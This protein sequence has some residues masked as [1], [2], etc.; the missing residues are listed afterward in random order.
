MPEH[1]ADHEL[2][3]EGSRWP[4][5]LLNVEDMISYR[6]QPGNTY[7]GITEP[8][9]AIISYTWGRWRLEKGEQPRIEALPIKGVPWEVPRVDPKHFTVAQFRHVLRMVSLGVSNSGEQSAPA[10][11]FVWLDVAC[12]P[13]WPDS[14]VAASEI[15]RQARI[16]R[17]AQTA[18][19]WL[20]TPT[21]ED[22]ADLPQVHDLEFVKSHG[23][24][25]ALR[26]W[27]NLLKDP[28]FSSMW[29]LQESF[30]QQ[31]AY[32]VTN[33]G[34]Y[35]RMG[36]DRLITYQMEGLYA[37]AT[38]LSGLHK[39]FEGR[40]DFRGAEADLMQFKGRWRETGIG[41]ASPMAVLAA[42]IGRKCSF[43]LDRVYGIMQ[44]FG[45]DFVVGKAA[46]PAAA[47]KDRGFTLNELENDLGTLLLTRFPVISQL[48][49]H[50]EPPLVGRAWRICGRASVPPEL[51]E[52]S[53]DFNTG[54]RD[55]WQRWRMSQ[56]ACKLSTLIAGEVRWANF[57]GAICPLQ[58]VLHAFKSPSFQ[59]TLSEVR[60]FMDAKDGPAAMLSGS[61]SRSSL[62][63]ADINAFVRHM[64]MEALSIL[65]LHTKKTDS[66]FGRDSNL[67]GLLLLRP[68]AS[69]LSVHRGR[70]HSENSH[71]DNDDS[72]MWAR[73][74][75]CQIEI[76]EEMM[77]TGSSNS[78][79]EG[80]MVDT[81]RGVSNHWCQSDGIWG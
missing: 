24:P 22:V 64:D 54:V 79:M 70:R 74:G 53:E 42:S 46:S 28:W 52:S 66:R 11:P 44:I 21:P 56:A 23:I 69:A 27:H 12:I 3:D 41:L 47:E 61:K 5:R 26:C 6:W 17:G 59:P 58:V 33:S 43:E 73:V 29:T 65:L 67:H 30:I 76:F 9:Y 68:G 60:M 40:Y 18:Y 36:D 16:F 49:V 45:D 19:I 20:T 38:R 7:G 14:S 31:S 37:S 13:Q 77:T 71:Y 8:K 51:A 57:E 62:Q 35:Q 55:K 81:L 80:L 72:Q 10:L 75:V 25:R 34:F 32:V 50:D 2:F 48:F 39:T 63:T 4:R 1:D 15:G 78:Y